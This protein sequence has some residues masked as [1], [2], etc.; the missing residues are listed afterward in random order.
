MGLNSNSSS[1]H[2]AE[3]G[4]IGG[5]ITNQQHVV[6]IYSLVIKFHTILRR[7]HLLEQQTYLSPEAAASAPSRQTS[8]MFDIAT[9]ISVFCRK[10]NGTQ[11]ANGARHPYDLIDGLQ[12]LRV[13]TCHH[14][15]NFVELRDAYYHGWYREVCTHY[16]ER[17]VRLQLDASPGGFEWLY[18]DG[19]WW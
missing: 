11:R 3:R 10:R 2:N 19:E 4:D 18:G 6:G 15:F 9:P 17:A 1:D 5:V 7:A 13:N 8:G 16:R 12:V 14:V